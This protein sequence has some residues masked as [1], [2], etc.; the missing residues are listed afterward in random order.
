MLYARCFISDGVDGASSYL[1][2]RARDVAERDR[3]FFHGD[4][5]GQRNA[6]PLIPEESGEERKREL[7]S[8]LLDTIGVRQKERGGCLLTDINPTRSPAVPGSIFK[9]T[10]DISKYPTTKNIEELAERS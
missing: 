7:N 4:W 9:P 10:T 2:F 8:P 6:A 1:P 3:L 5:R